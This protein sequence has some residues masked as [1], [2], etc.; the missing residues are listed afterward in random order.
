M[1]DDKLI[2]M[3]L[4][5]FI[6]QWVKVQK[7]EKLELKI[8]KNQKVGYKIYLSFLEFS[9]ENPEEKLLYKKL[10]QIIKHNILLINEQ[11]DDETYFQL[12]T[13]LSTIS[14]IQGISFT[15]SLAFMLHVYLI[16]IDFLR[17]SRKEKWFTLEIRQLMKNGSLS[18]KEPFF[19]MLNIINVWQEFGHLF[20]E[21]YS[22]NPDKFRIHPIYV[23]IPPIWLTD[24]E[25]KSLGKN[26]EINI[27][28][29]VYVDSE[30]YPEIKHRI[31]LIEE[32][33]KK[34]YSMDS[35]YMLNKLNMV[36]N[37]SPYMNVEE[38]SEYLRMSKNSLYQLTSK[39][40]IPHS[41]V[42]K[43]ILFQKKNIDDWLNSSSRR[44]S[45][46]EELED[47]LKT[48]VSKRR[49]AKRLDN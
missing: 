3:Q 24:S 43:N 33:L 23:I 5:E 18:K 42:G 12:Q 2:L 7:K 14:K 17:N 1:K 46:T 40:K 41:K 45:T 9:N 44:I 6:S 11:D 35:N 13:I 20:L 48:K 37:N 30:Y 29:P 38:C 27:T 39:K 36:K 32:K 22:K 25:F 34:A 15:Q 8:I 19:S 49:P 21:G 31:P 47:H 4:N 16:M 26:E 28:K 10:K